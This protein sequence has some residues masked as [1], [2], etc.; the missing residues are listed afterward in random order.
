MTNYPAVEQLELSSLGLV[1]RMQL[2]Q[3]ETF[4]DYF[5][6][7]WQSISYPVAALRKSAAIGSLEECGALLRRR[8]KCL[9][10]LTAN[11]RTLEPERGFHQA[12]PTQMPASSALPHLNDDLQS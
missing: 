1:S 8:Y 2:A 7:P 12:R 5:R 6:R 4:E 3:V 10:T 11:G 9:P